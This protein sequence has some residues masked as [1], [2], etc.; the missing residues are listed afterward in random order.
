MHLLSV[1]LWV[2]GFLTILS[3]LLLSAIVVVR[4][5]TDRQIRRRDEF[6]GLARPLLGRFIGGGAS[7]EEILTLLGKHRGMAAEFLVGESSRREA[8][9][10]RVLRPLIEALGCTESADADL[11]SRNWERRLRAAENLGYL[12]TEHS[13]QPL[14]NALGDKVLGVRFAAAEALARLGSAD[15]ISEI[16][17]AI[18][19]K[20]EVS[21]RRAAELILLMGPGASGPVLAILKDPTT[22]PNTIAIAIRVAGSLHLSETAPVLISLLSH[23]E[24]NIRLNAVRT[25]ASI[26]E[27]SSV[28]AIV[29]LALDDD[30][31]VRSAV[32]QALGKLKATGHLPVLLRG[33]SDGQWWVRF[34]AARALHNLGDLGIVALQDAT[35]HLTDPYGR[36]ISLQI[37]EEHGITNKPSGETRS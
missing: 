25:L 32:M 6:H 2:S 5:E 29:P 37:L 17:T 3:L 34:N 10:R 1:V 22:T 13:L 16:L 33:L 12:G 27:T 24:M 9:D 23:G 31:E 15:R 36:N 26:G 20:G 8:P 19:V 35:E 7:L 11:T 14:R 30:W 21:Q 18:D 28:E 4:S